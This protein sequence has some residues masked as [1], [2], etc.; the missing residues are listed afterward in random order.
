MARPTHRSRKVKKEE[1]KQKRCTYF[2]LVFIPLRH[3]ELTEM[4][5]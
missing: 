1:G 2:P 4:S 5:T 3:L